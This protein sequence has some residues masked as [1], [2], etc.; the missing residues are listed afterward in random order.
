LPVVDLLG[1]LDDPSKNNGI[2]ERE[3]GVDGC[4]QECKKNKPFVWFQVAKE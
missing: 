2:D 3:Y 4:Q 1:K